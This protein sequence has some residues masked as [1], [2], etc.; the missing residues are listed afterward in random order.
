[1]QYLHLITDFYN[2]TYLKPYSYIYMGLL[3]YILEISFCL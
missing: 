1:M 3:Q 2:E